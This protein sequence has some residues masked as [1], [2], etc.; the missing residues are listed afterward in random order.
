[1]IA[2]RVAMRQRGLEF[3]L[4][5]EVLAADVEERGVHAVRIED[6]EYLRR[7]LAARPVVVGEDERVC[8]HRPE[9]LDRVAAAGTVGLELGERPVDLA[10]E[11]VDGVVRAAV[12]LDLDDALEHAGADDRHLKGA[13]VA[14]LA[15]GLGALGDRVGD[16][17]RVVHRGVVAGGLGRQL[18]RHRPRPVNRHRDKAAD[19]HQDRQQ[20]PAAPPPRAVKDLVGIDLADLVGMHALAMRSRRALGH[21]GLFSFFPVPCCGQLTAFTGSR[22]IAVRT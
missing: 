9:L 6:A 16:L 20:D 22:R 7:P 4:I 11:G 15:V 2:D 8:R 18:G 10:G 17:T 5:Q 21:E 1:V 12:V 14:V 13:V 3:L 19:Q